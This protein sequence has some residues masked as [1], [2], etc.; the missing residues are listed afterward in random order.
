VAGQRGEVAF[1]GLLGAPPQFAG[2]VVP[3]GV[4]GVVVAV[5][6]QRLTQLGVS[7]TVTGEAHVWAAMLTGAAVAA[8]VAGF[9]TAGAVGPVGAGVVADDAGVNGAER[10]G[11]EGGEDGWVGG[12]GFRDAFAAGQ[13]GA[14]E[15]VGVAAVGLGAG[16]AGRGAAVAAGLVNHPVRHAE[17]GYRAQQLAGARVDDPQISVQA[18]GVGAPG[19]GPDVIEPAEVAVTAPGKSAVGGPRWGHAG[20]GEGGHQAAPPSPVNRVGWV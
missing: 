4:G 1:D 17:G 12:D 20:W 18:D 19:G 6:A 16:R 3:H 2:V 8:G 13:A 7:D 11:G 5:H 14:D 15:L 10:R 9:G